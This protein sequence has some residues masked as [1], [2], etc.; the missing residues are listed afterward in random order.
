MTSTTRVILPLVKARTY[1]TNNAFPRCHPHPSNRWNVTCH[2]QK[3]TARF[4]GWFD[5][6]LTQRG[7]DQAVA[8]GRAL[9]AATEN[10]HLPPIDVAFTSLL[11]RA[12]DTLTLALNEMDLVDTTMNGIAPGN[13]LS[14]ALAPSRY[15]IPV[16]SSWRLNERHYGA[17]VGM[18]KEGAERLYGKE[19]LS[20]WRDSWD[21]PPPP[22]CASKVARWS[23][24]AHCD[25]VTYVND[26]GEMDIQSKPGGSLI[27]STRSGL[28][29]PYH[30]G[31]KVSNT[32]KTT[33]RKAR[34]FVLREKNDNGTADGEIYD[35]DSPPASSRMPASESLRDTY[36]RVLPLWMQGI[37]PRL[38]AGE[39]VLVSA[40]ANTL[41]SMIHLI[42]PD[43]CTR[44][45]MK[46]VKV[47]SATPLLYEFRTAAVGRNLVPG[48]L[49]IV[50]PPPLKEIDILEPR[51]RLHGQWIETDEINDL[52]FC[53]EVGMRHLEHEIA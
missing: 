26:P 19:K 37:A 16:I 15:R 2:I 10:G 48:N 53:T 42:D 5:I 29:G 51:H 31:E 9:R 30:Y 49:S 32:S 25:R 39:T 21:V 38:R 8:A 27:G 35:S 36:E 44:Q 7:I 11:V 6:D 34:E 40:H 18:S 23:Q 4:T 22:M 1:A 28:D 12:R 45:N 13:R 33:A 52:S 41:R 50:R 17:L 24:E 46:S 14:M 3:T 43:V 20:L 47:P